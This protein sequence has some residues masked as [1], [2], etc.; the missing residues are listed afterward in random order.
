VSYNSAIV[1]VR[2]LIWDAW[3][4]AHI[5]RHQVTREE[6][7]EVCQARPIVQ[8]GYGGRSLVIGPT[9]SG[10]MLTI[11]LDPEG[12]GIYYP[13]TARPASR[14]ERAIYEPG[15]GGEA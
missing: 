4:E 14:R 2:R 1:Y 3:N 11:V 9:R 15:G 13:V 7:E 6:V 8:E 10:R 5:A 12:E